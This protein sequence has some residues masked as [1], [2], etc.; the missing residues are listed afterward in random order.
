MALESGKTSELRFT[1]D[2][3]M[4]V[5][6]EIIGLSQLK[7]PGALIF[8]VKP[9]SLDLIVFNNRVDEAVEVL[10]CDATGRFKTP[11]CCREIT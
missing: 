1:R 3:G 10:Q 8:V 11:R 9:E 2:L 4:A 7:L 5:E 6:G